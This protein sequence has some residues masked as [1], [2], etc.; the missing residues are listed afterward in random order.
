MP[1]KP[2]TYKGVLYASRKALCKAYGID[3]NRVAARLG[4]G[5]TLEEAIET[6]VGEKVTN[7]IPVEY[8][9]VSYPSLKNMAEKLG[10]SCSILQHAYYRTKD[11]KEAV[12]YCIQYDKRDLTVWGKSYGSLS[13]IALVFGISHYHLV[14]EVRDGRSPQEAVK[15]ALETEP[16]LFEGKRYASFGDLCAEYGIQP[17]NVYG[18]L[19]YGMGL[20]EALTRPLKRTGSRNYFLYQGREYESKAALCRAYGISILCVREQTRTN[21]ITFW[22][23]FEVLRKLKEGL[24]MKR[25]EMLNYIPHCRIRGKNYKTM[26]ELLREFGITATTFYTCKSRSEDKDVFTVLKGMQAETRCAYEVDGKGMLREEAQKLGYT[27]AAIDKLPKTELPK[28]PAMQ[29]FDFDTGCYDG[30][31][32]YYE[33][34]NEKLEE[35]ELAKASEEVLDL[36]ME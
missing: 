2:V 14:T 10:L 23:S 21:P 8:E 12:E 15:R 26:T 5:W 33:I 7:G 34:L 18:R 30:E 3:E 29:G 35:L 19:R 32:L 9:G 16:I 27:K 25:E 6:A 4:S 13:E 22:D 20:S 31:K 1:P 17:V 11:I 24:G 28:Y 36:K